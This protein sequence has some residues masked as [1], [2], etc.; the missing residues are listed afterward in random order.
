MFEFDGQ[1]ASVT[2]SVGIALFPENGLDAQ[3]LIVAADE[4]MYRSKTVGRNRWTLSAR[5]G[6]ESA[7]M[8]V[9]SSDEPDSKED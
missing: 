8:P 7:R 3:A 6:A 9:S 5:G 4:A 2:A 1:P